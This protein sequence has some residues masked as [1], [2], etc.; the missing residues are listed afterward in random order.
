MIFLN[1]LL[2]HQ[3]WAIPVIIY[4][5]VTIVNWLVVKF[6]KDI[7]IDDITKMGADWSLLGFAIC[8]G[9]MINTASKFRASFSGNLAEPIAFTIIILLGTYIGA[10]ALYRSVND[11]VGANLKR[12]IKPK[13]VLKIVTSNFLGIFSFITAWNSI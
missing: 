7:V 12:F 10:Y 6:R 3:E 1:W 2:G 8:I 13:N 4:L 11:D 5:I 9:A